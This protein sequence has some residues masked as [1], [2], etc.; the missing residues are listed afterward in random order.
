MSLPQHLTSA[1]ICC[2]ES[3]PGPGNLRQMDDGVVVPA[4]QIGQLLVELS[5]LGFSF[6]R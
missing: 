1:T 3:T 2:A 4:E 6:V 5:Q